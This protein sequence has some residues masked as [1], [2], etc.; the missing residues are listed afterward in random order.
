MAVANVAIGPRPSGSDGA[1]KTA[2]WIKS[3]IKKIPYPVEIREFRGKTPEGT[4][5]FRNVVAGIPGRSGRFV[6][7]GC[8]YDTK[9]LAATPDFQGANDGASG[10]GLVLAMMRAAKDFGKKPPLS[11][12]FVFFD[13]EECF[14]EYSKNDGL[15]GSRRLA[16]EW[17]K[18]G[19]L[20]KCAAVIILDMVGDKDLNITI[21]SGADPVL[22][23]KL[24][25]IAAKLHCAAN[26]A[27]HTSDIL[28]DHTPFQNEGI[29]TL[30]II[31]FEFGPSNLY[32]HTKADTLDKISPK[33]L[34]IVGDA[35]LRL[36]WS[37]D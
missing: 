2:V 7:I 31:D 36:V 26:F 13:G 37:I 20:K 10:V 27:E 32:W 11:L 9:R 8:H 1:L 12:K 19:S 34:K 14:V 28:D 5:V 25:K 23:R 22:R 24:L 4:T 15:Y 17:K 30:D 3:E 16:E 21:P 29:P 6:L 33:S 35:A 18:D